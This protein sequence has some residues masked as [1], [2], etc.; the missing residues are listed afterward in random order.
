M[1]NPIPENNSVDNMLFA[2]EFTQDLDACE[3]DCGEEPEADSGEQ[4]ADP[5]PPVTRCTIDL[6]HRR[7]ACQEA[8]APVM[9][10]CT[11]SLST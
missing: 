1:P 4:D 2:E 10:D 5:S 11:P 8:T 7:I 9:V 6:G 3:E